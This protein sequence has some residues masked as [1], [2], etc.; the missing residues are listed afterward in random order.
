MT[1][2]KK[3]EMEI[4][5]LTGK[6]N[7]LQRRRR[8]LRTDLK[9]LV[10]NFYF[11]CKDNDVKLLKQTFEKLYVIGNEVI[12]ARI[13]V[14]ICNKQIENF[15]LDGASEEEIDSFY[16]EIKELLMEIDDIDQKCQDIAPT[17]WALI[18]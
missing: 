4:M 13:V 6:V 15:I 9:E 12:A 8:I 2:F 16:D 14:D 10:N 11:F 17:V 5:A 1:V 3:K 7:A 18:G